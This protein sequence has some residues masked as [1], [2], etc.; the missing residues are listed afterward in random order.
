MSYRHKIKVYH[1]TDLHSVFLPKEINSI[2][3]T[4]LKVIDPSQKISR[5]SNLTC[6]QEG[7]VVYSNPNHP[8]AFK[9]AKKFDYKFNSLIELNKKKIIS[10]L[11]ND[12]Y[13]ELF[14]LFQI[15]L[16]GLFNGADKEKIKELFY[17]QQITDSV[18]IYT[19]KCYELIDNNLKLYNYVKEKNIDNMFDTTET[20]FKI[21]IKT[22]PV[23]REDALC[24]LSKYQMLLS[25]ADP[26]VFDKE[27]TMLKD[28]YLKYSKN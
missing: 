24:L 26:L 27:I 13:S 9:K 8:L 4:H 1:A 11:E 25:I 20:F 22:N 2:G 17:N 10:Y 7:E 28:I 12:K 23:I 15:Y 3:L 21:K 19:M 18:Y 5:M 14:S 6:E 16:R